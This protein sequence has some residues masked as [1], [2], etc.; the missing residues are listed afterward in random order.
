MGRTHAAIARTRFLPLMAAIAKPG[1]GGQGESGGWRGC[2]RNER[3]L[4]ECL[5]TFERLGE[6]LSSTLRLSWIEEL[7][8]TLRWQYKALQDRE[9]LKTSG[10]CDY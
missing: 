4:G 6:A 2:G 7:L 3:E 9:T 8:Q 10:K 1:E 5:A